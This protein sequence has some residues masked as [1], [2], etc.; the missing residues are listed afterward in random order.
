MVLPIFEP[1]VVPNWPILKALSPLRGANIAQR[2]LKMGSFYLFVHPKWSQSMC[3][4]TH[5]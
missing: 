2:G 3:G 1:F 5:F 4:K